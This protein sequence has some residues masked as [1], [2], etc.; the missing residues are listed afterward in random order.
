MKKLSL[1]LL[2]LTLGAQAIAES[3]TLSD[4]LGSSDKSNYVVTN[5]TMGRAIISQLKY[6]EG[7][8]VAQEVIEL[9]GIMGVNNM[10]QAYADP[11]GN[12]FPVE[13]A[14]YEHVLYKL[15]ATALYSFAHFVE[16]GDELYEVDQKLTALITKDM[17]PI[18]NFIHPKNE[19]EAYCLNV[20]WTGSNCTDVFQDGLQEDEM[21]CFRG[22]PYL[23]CQIECKEIVSGRNLDFTEGTCK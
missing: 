17:K 23:K 14:S 13:N 7:N 20:N 16:N 2:A 5:Y 15:G 19:K 1:L 9:S 10:R 21:A 3:P 22:K 6:V 4:S 12:T 18:V 11:R 8:P